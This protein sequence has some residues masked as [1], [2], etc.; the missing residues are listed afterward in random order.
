MK[1][2]R[3][4]SVCTVYYRK[5]EERGARSEEDPPQ[6]PCVRCQTSYGDTDMIIDPDELLLICR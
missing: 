3:L 5:G 4:V 6:D 1:L 2:L